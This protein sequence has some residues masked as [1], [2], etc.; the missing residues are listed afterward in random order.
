MFEAALAK[1]TKLAAI[2]PQLAQIK[3]FP[4]MTYQP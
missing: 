1:L 3:G 4:Q 2:G